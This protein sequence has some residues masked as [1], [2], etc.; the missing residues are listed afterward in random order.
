MVEQFKLL[1]FYAFNVTITGQGVMVGKYPE[2]GNISATAEMLR[3]TW[4]Q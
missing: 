1:T 4:Q 3:V 2:M